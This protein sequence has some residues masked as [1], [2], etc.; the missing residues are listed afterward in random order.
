MKTNHKIEDFD[1][2]LGFSKELIKELIKD[3][4]EYEMAEIMLVSIARTVS[5]TYRSYV[6][7]LNKDERLHKNQALKIYL[8]ATETTAEFL[9]I[10]IKDE[11][12]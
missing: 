6:E 2:V 1:D 11:E 4:D 7:I 10:M 8:R 9:R 12:N 3:S 5:E